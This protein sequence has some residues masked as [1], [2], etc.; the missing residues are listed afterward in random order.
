[1][2]AD[3]TYEKVN[4][5]I[6]KKIVTETTVTETLLSR[7]AL[8]KERSQYEQ[9]LYD[10]SAYAQLQFDRIDA[11]LAEMDN[12]KIKSVKDEA[13]QALPDPNVIAEEPASP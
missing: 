13:A 7:D 3:I 11:Q 10:A 8:K 5:F 6:I 2:S 4:D 1:M 9:N 12:Q